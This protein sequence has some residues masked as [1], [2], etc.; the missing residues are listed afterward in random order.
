[1]DLSVLRDDRRLRMAPKP[2][3]ELA[4][5]LELTPAD[6]MIFCIGFEDRASYAFERLVAASS[7][8]FKAIAVSYEPFLENNRIPDL[9]ELQSHIALKQITYDRENPDGA[10]LLIT[11]QLG[12]AAG[13]VFV[14]V[15]AMSRLLIVQ[16][17]VALAGAERR[18]SDVTVLYT[19]A[20]EYPPT[21]QKAE[22]AVQT[23][24]TH[25]LYDS[26]FLSK[27]VFGV[28][29]PPELSAYVL[30]GC[31]L[32]LITFPSFNVDQFNAL[33]TELQPSFLTIVH[34]TPPRIE[35]DWRPSV[36]S[37]LNAIESIANRDEVYAS[38][39]DYVDTM[40]IVLD[41]YEK[42]GG[43]QR[44]VVSPTGSKMQSVAV[45]ILKSMLDDLQV[46]YPTPRQFAP[47][48]EYTKGARALYQ[49]G[50]SSFSDLLP[51]RGLGMVHP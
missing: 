33:L 43:A 11:K 2:P 44:L 37:K 29:I 26:L 14:D 22:S 17:I 4:A 51:D 46:V 49:L 27:G 5:E 19:E 45:G 10:G 41:V 6:T 1:M 20:E 7:A 48:A 23:P 39:L 32:R 3:V 50:L 36:I 38:T 9:H 12:N 30:Q 25:S 40:E 24:Q 8:G 18:F 28:A 21:R 16:L 34:G 35:F 42:Y 13:R 15:S 47:S 31:P